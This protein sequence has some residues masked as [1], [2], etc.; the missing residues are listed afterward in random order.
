MTF[1]G[2]LVSSLLVVALSALAHDAFAAKSALQIF[3]S[4]YDT[5]LNDAEVVVMQAGKKVGACNYGLS[6]KGFFLNPNVP[7]V[8]TQQARCNFLLDVGKPALLL[9]NKKVLSWYCPP[10]ESCQTD[11]TYTPGPS[12]KKAVLVM[13]GG[14]PLQAG[15]NV[16]LQ[17]KKVTFQIFL[18][19]QDTPLP[20]VRVKVMQKGNL[21]GICDYQSASKNVFPQLQ[22]PNISTPMAACGFQLD[23][24]QNA[25]MLPEGGKLLSWH[26][27]PGQFENCQTDITIK[28]AETKGGAVMVF[29]GGE[30]LVDYKL[31]VKTGPNLNSK[32]TPTA[33]LYQGFKEFAWC[34]LP[35]GAPVGVMVTCEFKLPKGSYSLA[36]GDGTKLALSCAAPEPAGECKSTIA[37]QVNQGKAYSV[38]EVLLK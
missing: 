9:P 11:I 3:I 27:P 14:A 19:Q 29:Q 21:V 28:A 2:K 22:P 38:A 37:F 31:F 16:P 10:G 33:K 35:A 18:A 6:E 13:Q 23:S 34:P 20:G 24:S 15:G 25:L 36:A 8:Q 32:I 26:C 12:N 30:P 17:P 7:N 4:Q 5:P 1:V